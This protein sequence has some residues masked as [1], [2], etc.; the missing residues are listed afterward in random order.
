MAFGDDSDGGLPAIGRYGAFE[1]T[2]GTLDAM[3]SDEF[4]PIG[5]RITGDRDRDLEVVA[6]VP[7]SGSSLIE[8]AAIVADAL[9]TGDVPHHRAVAAADMG[10]AVV[11][12]GHTASERPGMA[13]LV[14]LVS[15]VCNSE[16]VDL[17][18]IDPQ[19]WS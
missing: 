3:F 18:D 13:A 11:D 4:G 7:G 17:T 5:L 12:P 8:E 19:T 2:L 1:G 16:V 15:E 6:V 14:S 10:L 9:V